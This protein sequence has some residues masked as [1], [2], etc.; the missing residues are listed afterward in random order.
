MRVNFLVAMLCASTVLT[1]SANAKET[2]VTN[3][4]NNY[5]TTEVQQATDHIQ[6]SIRDAQGQPI[7]GASIMQKGTSNGTISDINGHFSIKAPR[8][9]RLVISYTGFN[10]QEVAVN[11]KSDLNITMQE[12]NEN[13]DELVVIGY[14]TIKKTDLTGAA[15]TLKAGT[16]TSGITGNALENLQGKASGVAV[17]NDNRPGAAPSIRVRGSGSINASNEPLYVVDGFPLMD[18]NI[19]DINPNDIE[20]ME[21]LKDASSTAIYG[22]RGANGVVM[23]TTKKGSEGT[24]HISVNSSF[25]IQNAGRLINTISGQD[26]INFMN[27]GYTNQGSKAPFS[28]TDVDAS[29]NWEKAILQDNTL[30]QNHSAIFDGST[31]D[32]RYMLS[33]GYYNQDGLVAGQGYEKYTLHSNIEHKFNSW[34]SFGANLQY[35]YAKTDNYTMALTDIARFGWPTEPVKNEDGTYHISCLTNTYIPDAWN[36]INDMNETTNTT[37]TNRVLANTFMQVQILKDLKYRLSIGIDVKN[38]RNYTYATSQLA[39]RIAKGGY[40]S[41]S[42]SWYKNN[43]KIMENQLT[44][45]HQWDKHRLTADAVY[46]WQRFSYENTGL[47]GSGF[48]NDE[49][50]AWD[51]TLADKTSVTWNSTK[52]NN[53]LISFTGRASYAY[54][55]KY[56]LTVTNRWDGS[57]RFGKNNKWGYFPSVGAA[58][59]ATQEKF[60]KDNPIVTDLKIRTSFGITGNQEIGNYQSLAQLLASNYTDGTNVITGFYESIGN[61]DLKWERTNQWDFGFDLGLF[62]RLNVNFDYYIRTT[63]DLL[64]SVPIPS[65]SG[66]TSILSNIGEVQNHGWELTI[67]GNAYRDKDWSID[68]SVNLTYNK[69]EIKKLY[70]D[71]DEVTVK[72]GTTGINNILKVGNPVDAL[73]ARHSLGIIK[74][75]EQLDA[76]KAAVPNSASKAQLGD[77]MYEDV[78]GDGSITSKDYVCIGS[79][80]P[81]YFY[82]FNLSVQ[83]KKFGFSAYGQGGYKYASITG[84]EDS[85][86]NGTRYAIGYGNL[87]SYLL[88]GENQLLNNVYIPTEYAY[89]RMWS[90]SNPDGDYPTAG[91]H[92]VYL[93]DRTNGNWNYFILRN[94]QFSYDFTSLVNIPTLKK[95]EF[96]VNFQNFVTFANHRGY[97]PVN[98]DTSAPWTK[99]ILFGINIKF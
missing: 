33:A 34:L 80:Q 52:Y 89:K 35:T 86:N 95:L 15:S 32:T 83:Y 44:Y 55:D 26:F 49:T 66:Y 51:M 53:T 43:S 78:D 97:N 40:G 42:Q 46:S 87:S 25:G 81:K 59:R 61:G 64:Y 18:G 37:T 13:L 92:N 41:G 17:F 50:G 58:W 69:N 14:G 23:I 36:P 30:V 79:V 71:V 93:S 88:Y 7:I 6:G 28:S 54:D 21:I 91:A 73:Y 75:Q 45:N 77:E 67:G 72:S 31:K 48:Q 99:T 27:A 8:N 19:S 24:K 29:T 12:S 60:L 65:S 11:G 4:S 94:I 85:G 2:K 3:G 20:S 82:G 57:S 1:V 22:S 70:G 62:N 39:D 84:A 68:A 90:T 9:A 16:L 5:S 38:S 47:S 98:G 74:T 63:K 96:N 56:L 76:Y 10:K